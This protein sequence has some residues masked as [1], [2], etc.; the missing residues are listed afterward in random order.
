MVLDGLN[1]FHKGELVIEHEIGQDQ[2]GGAAHT[3]RTVHQDLPSW[4]AQC[5]VDEISS[6]LE[7]D[8]HVKGG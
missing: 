7:V 3:D 8:A 5:S 2:G 4:S 1:G 6:W